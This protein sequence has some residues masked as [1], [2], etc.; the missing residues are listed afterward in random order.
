MARVKV[1]DKT[2][3]IYL[4]EETI[5]NRVKEVAAAINKD[6]A[7]KRPFL[8]RDIGRLVYVCFRSF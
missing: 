1:H 4:S 5:L 7:S 2:F 8:H 6:Y 3:D